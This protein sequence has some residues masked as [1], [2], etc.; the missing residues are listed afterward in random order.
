MPLPFYVTDQ[1]LLPSDCNYWFLPLVGYKSVDLGR[2]STSQVADPDLTV[3][4]LANA[5]YKVDCTLFYKVSANA[6]TDFQWTWTIPAGT[7]AGL[8]F[9]Q[10]FGAGGGQTFDTNQWTDAAKSADATVVGTIYGISIDGV[11]ATAGTAGSFTLNWGASS[12]TP[13]TTLTARSTL[14]LQRIS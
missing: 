4:V 2:T 9:A 8:Y 14:M 5:V 6:G 12:A 13:T 10:Y 7:A 3:S 1:V 11:L